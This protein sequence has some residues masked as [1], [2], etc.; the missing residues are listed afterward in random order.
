ASVQSGAIDILPAKTL[1]NDIYADLARQLSGSA[2]GVI[3]RAPDNWRYIW[4]QFD[5]RWA[6]PIELSQDVRLR[7][8]L[9]YGL[10]RP[11][12][13]ELVHPGIPEA[14]TDSFLALDDPR[15]GVVGQPFA[16]Y[17]YDPTRAAQSLAEG[18]WE[19]GP[20]GRALNRAGQPVPL[21]IRGTE[22]EA[23]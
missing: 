13:R 9:L 14:D 1:S 15:N 2:Q 18:G 3:A 17:H 16:S 5:P 12:I 8:G 10:D 21:E 7:R 11:A 20:D 19:R 22:Q 4:F 23:S 6:K